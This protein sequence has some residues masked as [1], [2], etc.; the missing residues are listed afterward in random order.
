MADQGDGQKQAAILIAD[1][2][3]YS[4]LAEA[5]E[6]ETIA[7]VRDL[8]SRIIA[9]AAR[10]HEGRVVKTV[11]DGFLLEFPSAVPAVKAAMAISS[12][13]A[14]FRNA[15]VRYFDGAGHWLHHDRFEMFL[16]AAREFVR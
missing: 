6:A 8:G 10:E 4:A 9:P 11:G 15:D 7:A 3:G 12:K 1:V 5:R 13:A 14:A 2:A 16:A